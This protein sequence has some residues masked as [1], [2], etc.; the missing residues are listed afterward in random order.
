MP[1]PEQSKSASDTIS[2]RVQELVHGAAWC[3]STRQWPL[4]TLV[5]YL[6]DGR[7]CDEVRALLAKGN[8]VS[9]GARL[10][11]P[12]ITLSA[13]ELTAVEKTF[14]A[15]A[16]GRQLVPAEVTSVRLVVPVASPRVAITVRPTHPIIADV[17]LHATYERFDYGPWADL[18]SASLT[19]E[20]AMALIADAMLE[21]AIGD[22]PE[23]AALLAES[24]DAGLRLMA[25][26]KDEVVP[27]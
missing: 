22:D 3:V 20:Q 7:D 14:P 12:P 13:D 16:A 10:T 2:V 26:R 15:P 5:A 24:N 27:W 4:R 6:F 23:G 11:W 21:V 9:R 25:A 17:L 19:R 18:Y 8:G 1:S